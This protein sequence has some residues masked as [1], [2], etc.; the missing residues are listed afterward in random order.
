MHLLRITNCSTY[1]YAASFGQRVQSV[2]GV[3]SSVRPS[4]IPELQ[5]WLFK[6]EAIVFPYQKT[7]EDGKSDPWLIFHTSGTTG[8]MLRLYIDRALKL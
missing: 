2:L 4:V 1:L 7:W 3:N 5:E 6:E 8:K